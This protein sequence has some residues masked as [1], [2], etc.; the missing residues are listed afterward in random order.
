MQPPS[1]R[2]RSQEL[3]ESREKKLQTFLR[4]KLRRELKIYFMETMDI[5]NTSM[6]AF[7]V[8]AAEGQKL[9][10]WMAELLKTDPD[11]LEELQ[12]IRSDLAFMTDM[13][14][15][16]MYEAREGVLADM[17]RLGGA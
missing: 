3:E 12:E 14:D 1:K 7:A 8:C 11:C 13:L 16:A 17:K 10:A 9:Y 6:E 2:Q 15:K 4:T 5:F